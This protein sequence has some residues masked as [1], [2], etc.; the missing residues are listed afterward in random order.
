M[1][2]FGTNCIVQTAGNGQL[3]RRLRQDQTQPSPP[4]PA[5]PSVAGFGFFVGC[6]QL[7][8]QFWGDECWMRR[9]PRCPRWGK[10]REAAK[11]VSLVILSRCHSTNRT[12][13]SA[14]TG[15]Q[16]PHRG[17][18]VCA[19]P[20]LKGEAAQQRWRGQARYAE[21]P[22]ECTKANSYRLPWLPPG[23]A[24]G[25]RLSVQSAWTGI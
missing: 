13:Q 24:K 18:K 19:K 10:C 25:I 6:N 7:L 15:C 5:Q 23:E 8:R 2:K 9:Y 3:R 21:Y 16:L 14:L 4:V 12:P 11:G 20:P 22:S 17:A 1:P